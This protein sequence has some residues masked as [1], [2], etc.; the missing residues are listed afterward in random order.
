LKSASEHQVI[1]EKKWE[2]LPRFLTAKEDLI[3][4][5][6]QQ[7]QE[8]VDECQIAIKIKPDCYNYL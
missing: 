2:E 1:K 5:L 8:V 7:Q 4:K 3:Q 6:L